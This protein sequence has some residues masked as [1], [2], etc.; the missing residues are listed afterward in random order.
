MEQLS[1]KSFMKNGH[2]YHLYVYDEVKDVPQGAILKN[3]D[4]V[5]PRDQVFSDEVSHISFSDL[6]R[7]KLLLEK[8]GYW[9]DTDLICLRPFDFTSEYVFA[10]ERTE[11]DSEERTKYGVTWVNGCA[12]KVPA[13]SEIMRFC[14]G[15][16]LKNLPG[17]RG[18]ELGPPILTEAV[19]KFKL[20]RY[21]CS[22]RAFTPI[23][24]W[25]WRD[26]VSEKLST[27][28]K[29]GFKLMSR[30]YAVHLWDSMWLRERADK[31]TIFHRKCLYERLKA[32][33]L[34]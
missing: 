12:M 1:I 4:D 11:K 32:R 27:R 6:F 15:S 23:N 33:Y 18:W 21:V 22:Y 13:N 8:G 7:Y 9:A 14:Y 24:W 28:L 30:V 17:K 10:A 3:A 31:A 26:V 5:V 25:D 16:C 20:G 19:K 2:E 29:I 34:T